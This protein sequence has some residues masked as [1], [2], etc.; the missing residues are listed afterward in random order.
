MQNGVGV[1]GNFEK[2]LFFSGPRKHLW[3][4]ICQPPPPPPNVLSLSLSPSL[5]TFYSHSNGST[6]ICM[7]RVPSLTQSSTIRHRRLPTSPIASPPPR[8]DFH[9]NS[10]NGA[11][12]AGLQNFLLKDS[13]RIAFELA[14]ARAKKFFPSPTLTHLFSLSLSLSLALH[15]MC[16]TLYIPHEIKCHFIPPHFA[17]PS[18]AL[19]S[20]PRTQFLRP[21]YLDQFP[22][23]VLSWISFSTLNFYSQWRSPLEIGDKFH[24]YWQWPIGLRFLSLLSSFFF[25]F[26]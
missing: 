10:Q 18:V 17:F 9:L 11:D 8:V 1:G 19:S 15:C 25:L 5:S 6:L 13:M 12:S 20:S 4:A 16:I 7:L 14:H 26:W 23:S 24:C 2:K 21:L 3:C 22:P